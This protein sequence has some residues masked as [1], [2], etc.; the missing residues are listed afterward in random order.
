MQSEADEISKTQR[1]VHVEQLQHLGLQL[2]KLSKEQLGKIDLPD[3]L[4]EAILLAQKLTSN[5][6]IRR[7]N[8]YIGRLMRDVDADYIRNKL[9]ELNSQSVATTK[10]LHICE[11]WRERLLKDNQELSVFI[12]QYK[13]NDISELRQLINSARKEQLLGRPKSYR[14][15]FKIIRNIIEMEK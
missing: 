15:L 10:I 6:A 5:S 7:Q 4:L 2:V 12:N 11:L 9:A 1:K 13:P 14:K 8:Q 3:K